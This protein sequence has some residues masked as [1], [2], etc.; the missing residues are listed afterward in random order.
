[1]S[2]C[3]D[4]RHPTRWILFRVFRCGADLPTALV[5]E[6]RGQA[7]VARRILDSPAGQANVVKHAFIE[8]HQRVDA[9]ANLPLPPDLVDPSFGQIAC[10]EVGGSNREWWVL[11]VLRETF[12]RRFL[13]VRWP[14]RSELDHR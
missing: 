12:V 1:M 9:A 5:A 14:S 2:F 4:E 11:V 8:V 7:T 6:S 3:S 13:L 10:G